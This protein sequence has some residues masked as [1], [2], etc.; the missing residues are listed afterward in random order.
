MADSKNL[1]TPRKDEYY[2]RSHSPDRDCLV[3]NRVDPPVLCPRSKATTPESA[4]TSK[5]AKPAKSSKAAKPAPTDKLA[6][7]AKL[8][9]ASKAA[10][11]AIFGPNAGSKD[12]DA[13][14]QPPAKKKQRTFKPPCTKK[15]GLKPP[16]IIPLTTPAAKTTQPPSSARQEPP[17]P[18]P[19][20]QMSIPPQLASSTPASRP[21]CPKGPIRNELIDFLSGLAPAGP[22]LPSVF[23]YPDPFGLDYGPVCKLVRN[24]LNG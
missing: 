7:A 24:S 22:S 10:Q 12:P 23:L 15:M 17:K 9:P 1:S 13:A 6:K 16:S 8:H 14:Q 21:V 11:A 20:P 4:P 19:S 5:P 2:S 18:S 3:D